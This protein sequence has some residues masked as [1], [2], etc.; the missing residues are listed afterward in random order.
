M[1]RAYRVQNQRPDY[2]EIQEAVEGAIGASGGIA[3]PGFELIT[4]LARKAYASGQRL[5]DYMATEPSLKNTTMATMAQTVDLEADLL[6]AHVAAIVHGGSTRVRSTLLAGTTII[7][8]RAINADR[9]ALAANYEQLG[10]S[11]PNTLF[12]AIERKAQAFAQEKYP[13]FVGRGR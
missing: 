9:E 11:E 13:E 2:T 8:D 1:M 5:E 12:R 3:L 4:Q 6:T 10:I 7:P